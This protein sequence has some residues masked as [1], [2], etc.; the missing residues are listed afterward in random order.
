MQT[1]EEPLEHLDVVVVGAGLSGVCAGHYLETECSW[2]NY[3]I[4][5]ARDRVGGTWD[6]F[7]Y[8]GV[9]SDSDM[10]TLG[11]PFKPW[12][13]D[14]M[15]VAGAAIRAYI[16]EAA[17]DDGLERRIRLNHRVVGAAWDRIAARWKLEVERT[18][19][20]D[21]VTVTCGFLMA[22]GGYY[23]YDQGYQPQFAGAERFKGAIVHPQHWPEDLKCAG[24]RFVV[25]GSGATAVTLVPALAERGAQV[26]MLQRSPTYIASVPARNPLVGLA[27][28][29]LPD[30]VAAAAVRWGHA[31]AA[32]AFYEVSRR[33]PAP[34]KRLL[35]YGVRSQLP[36]H[37]DISTHFTPRYNP[38]DERMC[39]VPGGDLFKAI[40]SGSATVVTEHIEAF[41]EDGIQLR[42]GE[43]LPADVI[44]TA[45]GLELLFLGAMK[46][47]VDGIPVELS[48]R[49]AYRGMMLEGVPNLAFAI[50]YTNASWTLRCDLTCRYVARL[51][52]HM[53]ANGLTRC[54]PVNHDRSVAAQPLLDLQSGYVRRG[55][56]MMPR[57]GSKQP[58]RVYQNYLQDYVSTRRSRIGDG[59]LEFGSALDDRSSPASTG[60]PDGDHREIG[61]LREAGTYHS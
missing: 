37:Y 23:R 54:T 28:R 52:N 27:Q 13:S 18:D 40:R 36:D 29:V 16:E 7:R 55:A 22:C 35:L 10:F 25:I 48:S 44:V 8:P 31:L 59:A 57:Q 32:Q 47:T 53:R 9:R 17:A 14:R 50:G 26:T 42:S 43:L 2:A 45:T 38:W 30:R 56:A 11:Y 19:T 15:I 58:W 20:G 34:V 1:S 46:L 39:A 60:H 4:F 5:E 21:L 6:L 33:H 61:A 41:T 12:R 49:L 51:L 24:K 3:A